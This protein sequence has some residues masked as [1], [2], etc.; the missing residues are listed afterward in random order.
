MDIEV[1]DQNELGEL[2]HAC[3]ADLLRFLIARTGDA[4]EGEDILQEVW[5]RVREPIGKPIANGRAYLFR[6]AHNLVIDQ[7]RKRRGRIRRERLWLDQHFTFTQQ[8]SEP[9]DDH[10]V[11]DELLERE[12]AALLVSILST[13]PDR[14]RRAFQLHK[15]NGLSHAEV[16]E[17]LGISKSGVEKHMAV[18]MKYFRRASGKQ[19]SVSLGVQSL[20]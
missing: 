14:A 15:L 12:E 17:H 13:L 11:E 5:I 18:A 3:R 2:Y 16:A 8:G 4:D 20:T 19:H 10:S 9:V 6:V 7:L 1:A